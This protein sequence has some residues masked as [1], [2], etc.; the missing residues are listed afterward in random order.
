MSLFKYPHLFLD[1]VEVMGHG[2]QWVRIVLWKA[3]G[4]LLMLM[5][6]FLMAIAAELD[7]VTG[8][9]G[10]SSVEWES[11]KQRLS[12]L[13]MENERL[14]SENER[15]RSDL[16]RSQST[17]GRSQMNVTQEAERIQERLDKSQV[18]DP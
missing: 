8:D 4:A 6:C 7:R 18:L 14:K 11:A 9:A 12:R 16:D 2:K 17:F 3:S 15:L 10:K 13:E 5:T 1:I